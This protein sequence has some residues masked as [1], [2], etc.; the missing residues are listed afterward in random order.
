MKYRLA[1]FLAAISTISTGCLAGQTVTVTLPPRPT[2][3][4]VTAIGPYFDDFDEPGEW[5]TGETL[6]SRGWIESGRYH[7]N[8]LQPGYMVWSSQP[9]VFRDG[10]YEV[11]TTFISGPESSGYGLLFMATADMSAFYYAIIT[12]D[13]RYDV[14]FC[15]NNCET[16]QSLTEGYSPGFTIL[17][18][19]GATNRLRIEISEG[20]L[21][22][23]IN[24]AA[25][26]QIDGLTASSGLAG[27]IG[28]SSAAGGF[29]VAFDN[30]HVEELVPSTPS[31]TN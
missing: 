28:E 30:F 31:T 8:I 29:E 5:I 9:R 21:T 16:Q 27:L 10:I 19:D 2:V 22:F 6:H 11:E 17:T 25:A 26:T 7:M 4:V 24:G 3:I 23:L 14:G 13:G 12:G 20:T 1:V 15:R 18:T